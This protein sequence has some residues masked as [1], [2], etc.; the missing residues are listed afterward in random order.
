MMRRNLKLV[1]LK[2]GYKFDGEQIY[3]QSML[4]K[5]SKD[6]ESNVLQAKQLENVGCDII[7]VAIP[8]LSDIRLIPAIKKQVSIPVVA[9]THFDYRLAIE[10]ARAGA[11]KIRINPGNIGDECKIK[12]VIQAC[13]IEGIPIRIG[14]NSG[15]LEKELL[16]KYFGPK[17]E[18]LVESALNSI[19]LLEKF[20][21]EDI[22]VS[23]KSSDVPTTIK[24]YKM[25]S[26]MCRYP[27]HIGVTESGTKRMGI[28]KS[29]IGIGALLADEIGETIRVSLTGDP[30]E[31]V[32]VGHDILKSLNLEE[33]GVKIVSCPTCGRTKIDIIGLTNKIEKELEDISKSIKVAIMGCA[34][35]GP[36]EAKDADIGIA[37]GNKQVVLFKKG[38]VVRKVSEEE[39]V[40]VLIDEIKK[41]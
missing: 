37:G 4:N 12:K 40:K 30:V 24:A 13:K 32:K 16:A 26:E 25:L 8:S 39:I 6:I 1:S 17:A 28:M 36:G 18:A 15:S 5:P 41:M 7:R 22:V 3:V 27:L 34:V 23:I 19:N 38:K 14:V 9:D 31:E 29:S 33:T 35:N 21:F 10:S 20:D 2:N 11:D